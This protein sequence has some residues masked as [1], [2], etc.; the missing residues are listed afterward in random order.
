MTT[1]LKSSQ[2]RLRHSL[3]A[4]CENLEVKELSHSALIFFG[5]HCQGAIKWIARQTLSTELH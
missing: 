4:E 3:Y 5:R 2:V 1:A